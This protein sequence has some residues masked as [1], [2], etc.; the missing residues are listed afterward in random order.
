MST[1]RNA[2]VDTSSGQVHART[3]GEGKSILLMHWSPGTGAMY[4][5]VMPLLAGH[6]FRCIAL[7]L[8]GYGR[9]A[10]RPRA[11]WTMA[12]YAAN[13]AEVLSALGVS[14]CAA[15][16]G[17]ISAGIALELA[18]AKTVT[19][20][21]L[22]LDGMTLLTPPEA[23]ALMSHFNHLS[24]TVR[25]D[26]GHKSF[27]WDSV[28]VFLRVWDPG[29]TPDESRRAF[30]YGYMR[31]LL[32]AN[33]PAEPSPIVAYDMAPRLA[34]Y[35][36]PVLFLTAETE[37]LRVC[38]ERGLKLRPG[39]LGHVFPGGHPLHDSARAMEY[40]DQIVRFVAS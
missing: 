7:D 24:P 14:S 33:R 27:I 32:D 25:A 20:T 8:M 11:G 10:D 15:L 29:L 3:L 6:G 30:Y 9:S 2:Y 34:A 13:V 21:N 4:R 19:V 36:G 31:D 26:N 37:P 12:D 1:I 5:H 35:T 40:A 22:I 39:A 23:T 28:E 18:L 38:H 17:H 16:G